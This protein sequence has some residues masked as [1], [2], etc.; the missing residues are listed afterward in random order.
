VTLGEALD[1]LRSSWA[2]AC[3]GPAPGA[4]TCPCRLAVA[5]ARE[6]QRGAHIVARLLSDAGKV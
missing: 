6:L 2:C 1:L 5:E 3:I 4:S